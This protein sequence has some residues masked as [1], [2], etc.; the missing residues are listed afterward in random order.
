MKRSLLLLVL[1]LSS[2]RPAYAEDVDF[3]KLRVMAW[4]DCSTLRERQG[5]GQANTF[6]QQL[7]HMM[8]PHISSPADKLNIIIAVGIMLHPNRSL[9]YIEAHRSRT[10]DAELN[11]KLADNWLHGCQLALSGPRDSVTPPECK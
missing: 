9:R 6:Q 8:Q 4:I 10:G 3:C 5:D 11:G 7:A 1:F 2:C